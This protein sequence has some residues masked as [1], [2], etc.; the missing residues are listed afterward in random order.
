MDL[1]VADGS[2]LLGADSPIQ[3]KDRLIESIQRVIGVFF[4]GDHFQVPLGGGDP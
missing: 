3:I 1:V 4:C 2:L